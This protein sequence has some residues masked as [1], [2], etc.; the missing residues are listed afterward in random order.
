MRA[1][2]SFESELKSHPRISLS[3]LGLL[4]VKCRKNYAVRSSLLTCIAICHYKCHRLTHSPSL[5]AQ[6]S[7]AEFSLVWSS[8]ALCGCH[9]HSA[10]P[11][12]PQY[13]KADGSA[14]S[15]QPRE[16]RKSF[17]AWRRHLGILFRRIICASIVPSRFLLLQSRAQP[18]LLLRPPKLAG[19]GSIC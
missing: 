4:Q 16:I 19:T 3:D 14:P 2:E 10:L 5:F 15:Y 9:H 18:L 6:Q 7:T 13:R 11:P 8:R 17:C 1:G 12:R